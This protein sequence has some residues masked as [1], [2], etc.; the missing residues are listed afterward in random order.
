MIEQSKILNEVRREIDAILEAGDMFINPPAD[1]AEFI[2]KGAV[3]Q[4][5]TDQILSI[6]LN[7][8]TLS[9]LLEKYERGELYQKSEIMDWLNQEATRH[10]DKKLGQSFWDVLI[11]L[12]G[13]KKLS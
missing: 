3:K 5:R 8:I 6:K 11:H 10:K 2:D 1:L 9:E 12:G 13:H 7:G 4:S